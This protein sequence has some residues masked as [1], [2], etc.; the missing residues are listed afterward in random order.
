[1][2]AFLWTVIILMS[3][4]LLAE[5]LALVGMLLVV[6]RATRK[7]AE[8][9]REISARV[10]ASASVVKELKLTIQPR[11]QAVHEDGR[12]MASQVASRLRALQVTYADASRRAERIRLR[13]ND[14]VQ[15]VEQHR[16]GVVRE[17]AEPI[18]AAGQVLRG[19]KLALWFLSKVA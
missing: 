7:S 5:I 2:P 18:Q 19:I 9:S 3:A 10:Q 15:T 12:A 1:M 11:L 13:L 6:R 16:R 14:S 8:L 17:V 4:A